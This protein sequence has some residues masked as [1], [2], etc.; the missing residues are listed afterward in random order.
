M[1]IIYIRMSN[2]V[3]SNETEIFPILQTARNLKTN[4]GQIFN[5]NTAYPDI[6]LVP[7]AFPVI[8]QI[9]AGTLEDPNIMDIRRDFLTDENL[10]TVVVATGA[11]IEVYNYNVGLLVPGEY[12]I[13][14]WLQWLKNVAPV[15]S[16]N[17]T[18]ALYYSNTIDGNNLVYGAVEYD[19]PATAGTNE[20][21]IFKYRI[22]V[23][24]GA[25]AN[26]FSVRFDNTGKTSTQTKQRAIL[27]IIPVY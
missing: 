1:L 26:T 12:E 16:Y 23:P 5:I 9:N 24:V 22:T 13:S 18:L 25:S 21:K 11:D 14:I 19:D 6:S 10:T 17:W 8:T 27:N 2:Q 7:G 15:G 4:E 20:N 3:F